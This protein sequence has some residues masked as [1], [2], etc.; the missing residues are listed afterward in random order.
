[1]IELRYAPDGEVLKRFLLSTASVVGIQGPWGSGKSTACCYKLLLNAVRQGPGRDGKRRRRTYIVRN[2]YDDLN[3][4][5]LKTWEGV[6]PPD[7]FGPVKRTRPFEHRI[8]DPQSGLDWEVVFLALDDEN[9]RKKLLSAEMSDAW[10]NEARELPRGIIDDITGRLGRYP[11]VA[12]GG[13]YLPQ[14]IMD[15]NAPSEDHWWAIMSGQVPIPEGLGEA[16]RAALVKPPTWEFLIQPPG[17]LEVKDADGKVT[18]YVPNPQAENVKWLRPGYYTDIIQGKRPDW[19]RVNVLNRPG[20]LVAGKPVWPQFREDAHVAKTELEPIEGHPIM[21]GVDFGRTP[22][23]VMGQRVFDRWRILRELCAEG[24]GARAFARLL[25][26]A[27]AEWFPGYRYAIWGDPAGEN[28]E[29]SDDSSPFRMFRA[30]GLKI[31]PAPTNDPAVRIAAVEELLRQM[32]DGAPRFLL[33]PRCTILK[34]AMAGGYHFRRL[35]VSGERYAET[36]DKNRYSHPADALQYLVVGA[37]EGRAL[38][39][40][41]GARQSTG[42]ARVA[43]GARGS[44]FDRYRP[45]LRR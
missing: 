35:Q 23:A 9:D 41:S 12:D 1:M 7:K 38:L 27:L 42:I 34:A 33:S 13:C 17:L 37:G 25:K 29:Q 36:P 5:T 24:M 10:V 15:T 39:N 18:G 40:Q 14:L 19:I 20:R 11:S 22:A 4:T 32:I 8:R 44:V 45:G 30:E 28:L 26:G 3:R 43:Q 6:F 31:L 2:T 21:V 16:E